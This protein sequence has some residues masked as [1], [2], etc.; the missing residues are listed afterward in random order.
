MK[1]AFLALLPGL[2]IPYA[3]WCQ[4]T[5]PDMM[6][7]GLPNLAAGVMDQTAAA[8]K[9][10]SAYDKPAALDAI[11]R[12]RATADQILQRG[13]PAPV[14]V[15]I[16]TEIETTST[17]TPV[18]HRN[19]E[20]TANRMKKDTSIRDVQAQTTTANLNVTA[21]D[22]FLAQAQTALE[23][24][25]FAAAQT[26]LN[27]VSSSIVTT[28]TDGDMPLLKARDNLQLARARVLEGKYRDAVVPLRSAAEALDQYARAF[29]GPNAEQAEYMRAQI[30]EYAGKIAHSHDDAIT[31]IDSWLDPVNQWYQGKL[32]K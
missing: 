24:D 32:P 28:H 29:P 31:V 14:L 2:L 11:K 3:A 15:P 17:Y 27:G 23:R 5:A 19:G 13:G 12:A 25:D 7:N 10:L 20:M 30:D 1:R 4:D 18:K 22:D 8:R 9:A 6:T 26:A 21:A 16:H